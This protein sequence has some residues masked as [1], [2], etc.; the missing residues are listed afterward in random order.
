MILA[1]VNA[2]AP[3]NRWTRLPRIIA[4]LAVTAVLVACSAVRVVYSQAPE[5]AYWYLDSYVDFN[6]EQSLQVR[7]G[8][9]KVQAWHRQTQLPAYID[10]LQKLQA[11]LP[12][13]ISAAESCEIYTDVRGKLMAVSSQ[14][15][16]TAAAIATSIAASQLQQM[17]TRFAKSNAEYREDF[18]EGTAQEKRS[19]R[20][21]KAVKRAEMLYGDL[22]E[23]QLAVIAQSVDRS[24]FNP[25]LALGEWQR[26][27][28]DV[29]KTVRSVSENL[30]AAVSPTTPE[31]TR[32]A[33][34]ALIERSAES[35]DPGYRTYLKALTEQTCQSFA[36]FHNKTTPAQ[37]KKAVETLKSYEQDFRALNG[38]QQFEGVK[39]QVVALMEKIRHDPRHINVKTVHHDELASRRFNNFS[40]G[41]TTLEDPEVLERLEKLQG[42]ATV[43]A[44][45]ALLSQVDSF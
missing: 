24:R 17:G 25:T 1:F 29:L 12:S 14:M 44:F 43:S 10:I 3:R 20:L 40:L 7:A 16:P 31:K 18:M 45:V 23:E 13:N 36:E 19:K 30:S 2:Y 15:E 28:Q 27:Q 38:A 22:Q 35:P 39:K 6:G 32:Q 11:R 26:R 41:Y 8:L 34:R 5:L 21:K 37:R 42:L 9:K 33:M 4:V